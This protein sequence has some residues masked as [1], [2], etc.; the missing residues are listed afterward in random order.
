MFDF[1]SNLIVM[2]ISYLCPNSEGFY[3]LGGKMNDI[4]LFKVYDNC[5]SKLYQSRG[6]PLFSFAK[7]R[8]IV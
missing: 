4:Y 3:V 8:E 6:T 5:K 7:K 2:E 1:S